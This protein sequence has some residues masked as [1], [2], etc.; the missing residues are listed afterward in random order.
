MLYLCPGEVTLS[1]FVK[2]TIEP[3]GL[4]IR[5]NLTA[6]FPHADNGVGTGVRQVE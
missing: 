4:D 3:M 6:A 1:Q 5:S 2:A